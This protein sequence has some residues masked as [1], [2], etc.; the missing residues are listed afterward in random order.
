MSTFYPFITAFRYQRTVVEHT[1]NAALGT[2]TVQ[3]AALQQFAGGLEQN[4]KQNWETAIDGVEE[5]EDTV[6]T[7]TDTVD[8]SFDSFLDVHGQIKANTATVS[9]QIEVAAVD[10]SAAD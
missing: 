7:H 6:D 5:F 2:I 9:E 4:S 3:K 10:N 1:Q 8:D